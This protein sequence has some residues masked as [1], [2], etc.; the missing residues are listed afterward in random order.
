MT[1]IIVRTETAKEGFV[2]AQLRHRGLEAWVPAE[3]RLVRIHRLSKA[4]KVEE[5]P[6][7]P[8][9]LFAAVPQGREAEVTGI[10]HLLR[11]ERTAEGLVARIPFC[12]ITRFQAEIER[13]NALSMALAA[14]PTKREK[15]RW[16]SLKEALVELVQGAACGQE[17]MAA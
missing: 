11:L 14:K 2:S 1:W 8:R 12:Q 13:L 7:V 10:R 5:Y 3:K 17:E 15:A 6:I 16:R 9:L 4:R